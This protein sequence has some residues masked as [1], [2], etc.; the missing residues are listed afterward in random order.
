MFYMRD[1]LLLNKLL[2]CFLVIYFFRYGL[3][4]CSLS[5]RVCSEEQPVHMDCHFCATH[6]YVIFM[7]GAALLTSVIAV[8]EPTGISGKSLLHT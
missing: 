7:C 5:Y 4:L 6:V 8:Q 2:F 3:Q 1:Q